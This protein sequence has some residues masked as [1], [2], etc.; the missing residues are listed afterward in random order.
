MPYTLITGASKGI[1]YY[2]V[3]EC[4]RLN[5]N[6]LLVALSGD[7]LEETAKEI[8][9]NYPVDVLFYSLDITDLEALRPFYDWCTENNI[10]VNVL[11]NNAGM[12]MQGY[13]E[14]ISLAENLKMINLNNQGLI[15]LTHMFIPQIKQFQKG[16]I[17]NVG[18]FASFLKFPYKAVY[19]GTKNFVLAFSNALNHELK[20]DNISVSCLCPGPT[21]TNSL[22]EARTTE[23]GFK[24]K[25]MTLTASKVA[26]KGIK[27]M[28]KGKPTIV[29]G[30]MNKLLT[31]LVKHLPSSFS[32]KRVGKMFA[33][34]QYK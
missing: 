21:I 7:G 17:L 8:K 9:E 33:N 4:A 11:I 2:M 19:S 27:G 34:S 26:E 3:K 31:F 20:K 29:P 13:F 15:A 25:I 30:A 10:Q 23:Q 6:L 32:T 24:A 5:H 16:Y 28:L 14:E 18:S 12:G 1:G 22:V